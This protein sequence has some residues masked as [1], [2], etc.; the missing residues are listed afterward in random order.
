MTLYPLL[1]PITGQQDGE[2]CGPAWHV[3]ANPDE[4]QICPLLAL[5]RY[6]FVYPHVLTGNKALFEGSDQYNRYSKIFL[7][8][9]SENM[10]E[11]GKLG[12]KE[13]D[14][15]T[16]SSRKGVV[17][18]VASGCTVSPPIIAIFLRA[19]WVLGGVKDKYFKHEKAADQYVGRCAACLDQNDK[20]FAISNPFFDFDDVENVQ[21]R[22]E[23]RR[24][25]QKWICDRIYHDVDINILHLVQQCFATICFHQDYLASHMS[26]T[27]PL[28]SSLF[29]KDIPKKFKDVVRVAFPW[30]KPTADTP[31]FTGIP[32]NVTTMAKLEEVQLK[33]EGL[34]NN[35]DTLLRAELDRRGMGDSDFCTNRIMD[36]M[37][38]IQN[39][40]VS[41]IKSSR[42]N[43]S[44]TPGIDVDGDMLIDVINNDAF[45]C[46]DEW[47]EESVAANNENHVDDETKVADER[48][49]RRKRKQQAA[50]DAVKKRLFK[51]GLV[52]GIMTTLPADFTFPT[53]TCPQLIGNWVL[54]NNELNIIP[55]GKLVARDVAHVNNGHNTHQKMGRFMNVIKRLGLRK[56]CWYENEWTPEKVTK[57]WITVS[58][59]IQR[60]YIKYKTGSSNRPNQLMWKTVYNHMVKA[61]AF[62]KNRLQC[63][64]DEQWQQSIYCDNWI[65]NTISS[66]ENNTS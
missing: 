15:G 25:I 50:Q 30:D 42:M 39:E 33:L 55:F 21:E 27:N 20:R 8:V 35:F 17:T 2:H 43:L 3:Y 5:A 44:Q 12:V 10:H 52:K 65:G 11:L 28:R 37:R 23:L 59:F 4:P 54:G 58:P 51:I 26:P 19:G 46:E 40:L 38:A 6:L 48:L 60:H 18:Y 9:I 56:R 32:V 14:L 53:L 22:N 62:K 66:E 41:E 64:S 1:Y 13:G 34:T 24:E 61:G 57:L 29:F 45:Q 31:T 63:E 36:E 47:E 49:T 16:H 7:T